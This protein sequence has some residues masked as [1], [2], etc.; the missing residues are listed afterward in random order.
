M[1]SV[2]SHWSNAAMTPPC[3]MQVEGFV[4]KFAPAFVTQQTEIWSSI[5]MG[6]A[7]FFVGIFV[8]SFTTFLVYS[9]WVVFSFVGFASTS[10]DG[11]G[12]VLETDPVF[13]PMVSSLSMIAVSYVDCSFS[14]PGSH[15]HVMLASI[16]P[17]SRAFPAVCSV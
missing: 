4:K 12:W 1:V 8:R 10:L 2:E 11:F 15:P 3:R 13:E 5:P 14:C 16:S 7:G 9:V 6:P 17:M